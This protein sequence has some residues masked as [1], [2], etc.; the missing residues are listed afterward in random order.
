MLQM[1]PWPHIACRWLGDRQLKGSCQLGARVQ[2]RGTWRL[3]LGLLRISKQYCYFFDKGHVKWTAYLLQAID[4]G[5]L[6][7]V[8]ECERSVQ[9]VS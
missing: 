9:L 2:T 1:T 3:S 6:Q 7:L 4:E 8:K 5:I